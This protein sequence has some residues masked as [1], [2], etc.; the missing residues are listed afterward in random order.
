VVELFVRIAVGVLVG[1]L[2]GAAL[3]Y[4]T[5]VPA[6]GVGAAAGALG[7]VLGSWAISSLRGS[8]SSEPEP[9]DSPRQPSI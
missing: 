2:L 6:W 5:E 9:P 1:G 4:A 3:G 7:A 8:A